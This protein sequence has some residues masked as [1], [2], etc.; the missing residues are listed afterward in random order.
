MLESLVDKAAGL[1]TPIFK[2]TWKR[3]LLI[4]VLIDSLN[5]TKLLYQITTYVEM[6]NESVAV[7]IAVKTYY[8][9]YTISPFSIRIRN[10]QTI[11]FTNHR[12]IILDFLK[13]YF[14]F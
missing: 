11:K 8:F 10:Y 13:N 4:V 9:A 5:L 6:L 14:S 2:N 3:L 12:L 7:M 1:R